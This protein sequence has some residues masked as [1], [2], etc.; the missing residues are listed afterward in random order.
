MDIDT[1]KRFYWVMVNTRYGGS[2]FDRWFVVYAI[3]PDEATR[4]TRAHIRKHLPRLGLN[5]QKVDIATNVL[6]V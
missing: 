3:N 4:I 5:V 1:T 6:G 2:L